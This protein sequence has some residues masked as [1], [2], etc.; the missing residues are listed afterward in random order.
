MAYIVV[1]SIRE[2]E[3]GDKALYRSTYVCRLALVRLM[4]Q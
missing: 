1:Y 2:L 4:V 3:V